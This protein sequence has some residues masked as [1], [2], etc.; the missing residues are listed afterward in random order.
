MYEALLNNFEK[1]GQEESYKR[2]DIEYQTFKWQHSWKRGFVWL[3][4]LWWNFGY[5]KEYVIAWIILSLLVFGVINCFLLPVLNDNVY[6]VIN[7]KKM[8][9]LS[10]R[11]RI[12]YSVQ[13]TVNIFFRF[14]LERG[15]M[16]FEKFFPTLYFFVIYILGVLCLGYLANFILQK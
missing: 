9:H 6:E 5:D 15:C 10:R 1:N 16:R 13:Y 11:Q 2:L 4:R 8:V 12:W 14:T 7:P 3:G